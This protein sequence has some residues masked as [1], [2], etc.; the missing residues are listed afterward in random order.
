MSYPIKLQCIK[1]RS[2]WR[3]FYL[4]IPAA[5]AEALE[6]QEGEIWSWSVRDRKHLCLQRQRDCRPPHPKRS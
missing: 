1:R 5:L 2:G 4:P 6:C 3:Q